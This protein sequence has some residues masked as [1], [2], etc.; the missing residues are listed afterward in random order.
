MRLTELEPVWIQHG[1]DEDGRQIM[2]TVSSLPEADGIRFLCP[3]CYATNGGRVGTH[4]VV[5]WFEGRVSD[6]VQPGPGRWNPT[7]DSFE[8][9]SFVPGRKT[10]SVLLLGGCAWHG[11]VTNGDVT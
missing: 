11:F 6:D 1:Q 10:H 5:C 3:K 4:Q 2:R 9:L 7:G 8:S